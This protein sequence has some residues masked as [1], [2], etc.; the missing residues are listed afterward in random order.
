[1]TENLI[2]TLMALG[3]TRQQ[4]SC[5]TA[6]KITK[7]YMTEAGGAAI[8][9]E[10]GRQ[11]DRMGQLCK[12]L[13][14]KHASIVRQMEEVAGTLQAL[15]EAQEQYGAIT[16]EKAKNAVALYA[17]LISVAQKAGADGEDS[18][19]NAGYIL[20]AYLGGQAARNINPGDSKD[21]SNR[22]YGGAR[23]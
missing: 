8:L 6:E 5:T 9:D 11:V 3:L 23:I 13:Q 20:Y 15:T 12:E 7:Y 1:M 21:Q 14:L 10:A 19:Q 22:M 18:V 4:A 2:N 16:E 17:A